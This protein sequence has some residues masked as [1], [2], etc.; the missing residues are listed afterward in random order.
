MKM[1]TKTPRIAAVL[2][3]VYPRHGE[4]HVV[5]MERSQTISNHRGQ[6]SLPGGS[7]DATDP[8]L[9]FTALRETEEELGVLPA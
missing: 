2:F 1:E 6:I 3:L 8:T 5:F 4:P 9:E 7:R